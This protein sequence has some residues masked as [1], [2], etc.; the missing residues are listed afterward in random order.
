MPAGAP[1]ALK[2]APGAPRPR[3]VSDFDAP[4]R[5]YHLQACGVPEPSAVWKLLPQAQVLTAFGL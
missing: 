3:S 1:F 4:N 2:S 5:R